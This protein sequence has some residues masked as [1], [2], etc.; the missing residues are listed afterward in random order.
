MFVQIVQGQVTDAKEIRAALDRWQEQVGPKAEGY[1]GSTSGVA[2]DGQFVAVVRFASEEEARR[3]SERPEQDDW[4]T[5]T[6][7]L[8][9]GEATFAN[10]VEVD[11]D[12]VGDPDRAGFVQIVQG[13]STDPGR[14]REL[15]S[16]STDSWA[17]FRPDI[18]GSLGVQ[19]EDG[20]YTAVL[21]FTSEEEAREGERKEPPP[22][23]QREM[24]EMG[25]LEDGEPTFIDLR[26]PWFHTAG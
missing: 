24:E 13:R 15:M 4:W 26:E 9:T 10:S 17:E 11:V 18:I 5:Q 25:A 8:F 3:N 1:L 22:E 19:H 16:E 20:R 6:A 12:L 23:L 2:D 14:A 7:K 21:Y